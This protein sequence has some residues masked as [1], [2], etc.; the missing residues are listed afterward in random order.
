MFLVSRSYL[1]RMYVSYSSNYSANI[2]TLNFFCWFA[3]KKDNMTFKT[4]RERQMYIF[5][6]DR[7]KKDLLKCCVFRPFV[8]F[9][10]YSMR[11]YAAVRLYAATWFFILRVYI[12]VYPQAGFDPPV[13]SD[14]S[15]EVT[16]L[17]P[18]H[19]AG[20]LK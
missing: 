6:F 17:H 12:A 4:N 3:I 15:Y 5:R 1:A 19:L 20:F 9:F 7:S 16:A 2:Q 11:L 14:S 10:I 18:S 8:T 13:Q